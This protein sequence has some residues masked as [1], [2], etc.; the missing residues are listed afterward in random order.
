LVSF[1]GLVF[2]LPFLGVIAILIKLDSR[3][4]VFFTHTRIGKDGRPFKMYKFR[5][6]VETRVWVGPSL[7]P[8]HDPRVTALGGVLRRF[9]INE[10][11]Q[12]INVLKGEM[13][14]VGPRP[15]V[16][17][18]VSL[19]S[20][21]ERKVLSVRPG[22]VGPNQVSM[23]NEEELYPQGADVKDYYLKHIMPQKLKVDLD[24]IEKRSF[25]K[26]LKYLFQGVTVTIT[27][28]IG[29]RHLFENRSQIALFTLDIFL[30]IFSYFL[31]YLLRLDGRF[32][33]EDLAI[34]LHILPWLIV[35]RMSV[36]AYFGLYY[37]LIRYISVND[38]IEIVKGVTFSTILIVA[39][40]F[41]LGERSH[42]RAVFFMDWFILIGLMGGS[43]LSLRVLREHI[44]GRN[45]GTHKNIL[46]YGAGDMGDLALRYLKIQNNG[47][48]V[49]FIDDDPKKRRKY[50]QGLKVLGDRYDIGALARL[51]QVNE[52]VVAISDLSRSD[53][54]H[55]RSICE[56][57]EVRCEAL[58]LV[59]KPLTSDSRIKEEGWPA[60]L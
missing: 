30:C 26:D 6:M 53:L 7:S 60:E 29:R 49:G 23:R 14:F 51:Y 12:L 13:S 47:Q 50:F 55:I 48:I 35:I 24:Y 43:R 1:M 8:E 9:K 3:G 59:S 58:G 5:T 36:F 54:G 42:P 57:A 31:A 25:L 27:G 21:E 37:T 56:K 16:P 22:I 10:L 39:L 52:V 33:P 38:A 11:P 19:Y 15:E 17:E 20:D 18:F 28:A 44:Q 34:F 40:V 2:L 41:F 32:P 45:N 46:I 4:P